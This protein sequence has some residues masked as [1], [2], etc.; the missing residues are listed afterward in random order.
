VLSVSG[1]N[2]GHNPRPA[3][4]PCTMPCVLEPPQKPLC[5]RAFFGETSVTLS[6]LPP[7]IAPANDPASRLSVRSHRRA[8][9]QRFIALAHRSRL[10]RGAFRPM[11][12]KL[13]NRLRAGHLT[14]NNQ[15]ASFRFYHQASA[16][17]R[18]A[19][20]NPDYNLDELDFLRAH[21]PPGGVS[22]MSAANVGTYAMVLAHHVGTLEK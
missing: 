1:R 12:S 8:R 17:E 22:S 15:G 16:T 19:L 7:G 2:L 18:G 3:A 6:T 11:L 20:F 9:K 21:T 4:A 5:R 13:I 10:K 14:S